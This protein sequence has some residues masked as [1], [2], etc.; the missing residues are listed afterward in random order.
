MFWKPKFGLLSK[1]FSFRSPWLIGL[2]CLGLLQA[3]ANQPLLRE[4]VDARSLRVSQTQVWTMVGRVA[5]SDGQE[6]GSGRLEWTA[7]PEQESLT[8]RAPLGQGGWKLKRDGLQATLDLGEQR[9]F[10]G[11]SL[12]D[13]LDAHLGWQVPVEAMRY[14]MLGIPD[15]SAPYDQELGEDGLPAQLAQAGWKVRYDSFRGNG[16]LILPR[17][18]VA[19]KDPYSVKLVVSKWDTFPAQ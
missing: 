7:S 1:Y 19:E 15:P 9:V 8:F 16:D 17:K 3:C 14:W 5:V 13:L 4:N 11:Q 10:H 12:S 2:V 18:L 6:G